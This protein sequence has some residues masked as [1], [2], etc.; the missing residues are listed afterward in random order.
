MVSK[1]PTFSTSR[2]SLSR[3]F[4]LGLLLENDVLVNIVG[5]PLYPV[6][7]TA[8]KSATEKLWLFWLTMTLS[9]PPS[10]KLILF[11]VASASSTKKKLFGF[12]G[13]SIAFLQIGFS[14]VSNT[15]L[16]PLSV[17]SLSQP[18]KS[19]ELRDFLTF[20]HFVNI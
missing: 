20:G 18:I 1:L 15:K 9:I 3:V 17:K 19:Q 12:I 11:P 16:K 14:S 6:F 5:T 7:S 8:S 2:N 13:I 4:A 10:S